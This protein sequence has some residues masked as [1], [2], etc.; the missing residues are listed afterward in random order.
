M[1]TLA[2]SFGVAV[3]SLYKHV[4][5]LAWIQNE[6]AKQG[7]QDLGNVLK[8]AATGRAQRDALSHMAKAYRHFAKAYPGRYAAIHDAH[9][10]QDHELQQLSDRT[11]RPIYDML[12][13]YGRTG[14]EATY[15][16]RLL[17]A[18]L[19]GFVTLETTGAFGIPLDIEQSFDYL[20]DAMDAS[21]RS[22]RF[23]GRY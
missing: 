22:Y 10:P 13:T 1:A 9:I 3:P 6:I 16:V 5:S 8:D 23:S 12:A 20:I 21:F 2:R 19:H 4:S 15:D 17:R 14:E 7:L 11:L 18:A